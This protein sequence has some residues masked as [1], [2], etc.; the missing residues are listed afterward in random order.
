MEDKQ[1]SAQSL[2]DEV[3]SRY[4]AEDAAFFEKAYLFAEQVH[5]GQMRF[6]ASPVHPHGGTPSSSWV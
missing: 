3:K 4:S 2:L 6:R 1:H 5:Q